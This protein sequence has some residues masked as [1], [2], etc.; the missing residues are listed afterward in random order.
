MLKHFFCCLLNLYKWTETTI[1]IDAQRVVTISF[2]V[3]YAFKQNSERS[4]ELFLHRPRNGN[5]CDKLFIDF[6]K[7]LILL[8]LTPGKWLSF[9]ALRSNR[10]LQ[11][12]IRKKKSFRSFLLIDVKVKR[13]GC[14]WS[15][16]RS[17]FFFSFD[18]AGYR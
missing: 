16:Y 17:Y 5:Y 1:N 6:K 12:A 13:C 4:S 11:K 7:L 10:Q 14:R 18:F 15:I 2:Y 8:F 9:R 3:L